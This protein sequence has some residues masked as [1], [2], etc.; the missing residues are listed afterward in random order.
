MYTCVWL[1]L[2][3]EKSSTAV[4]ASDWAPVQVY[5]YTGVFCPTVV[6]R[7]PSG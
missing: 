6:R 5:W 7:S 1:D 4:K 3:S 2:S